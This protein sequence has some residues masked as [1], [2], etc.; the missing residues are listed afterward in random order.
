MEAAIYSLGRKMQPVAESLDASKAVGSGSLLIKQFRC[1]TLSL[2]A[3]RDHPDDFWDWDQTEMKGGFRMA[4]RQLVVRMAA[5]RS[6]SAGNAPHG[7]LSSRHLQGDRQQF[8]QKPPN[9]NG[10]LRRTLT[11]E[12]ASWEEIGTRSAHMAAEYL[13]SGFTT[14]RDMGG[15]GSGLKKTIDAG[16]LAGPRVYPGGAYLS[17][18]SGHGDFRSSSQ[19]NPNLNA[20]HGQQR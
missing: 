2:S 5:M 13:L 17:Q 18:T 9:A 8:S 10:G 1:Q 20:L 11:M 19:R 3:K 12:A 15:G 7:S 14:V 4:N 6:R 16:L